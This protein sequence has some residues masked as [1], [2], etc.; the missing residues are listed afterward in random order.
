MSAPRKF[1]PLII[2]TILDM[3]GAL[4]VGHINHVATRAIRAAAAVLLSLLSAIH[5]RPSLPLPR[6]I[7]D[8]LRR[9]RTPV[10][11]IVHLLPRVR[12][13]NEN[14]ARRGV[15][16]RNS[17]QTHVQTSLVVLS[18]SSY[19]KD[20]AIP[21]TG[22]PGALFDTLVLTCIANHVINTMRSRTDWARWLRVMAG[23]L[24]I[25]VKSSNSP[26]A[27]LGASALTM[28]PLHPVLSALK[29]KLVSAV[30]DALGEA[31]YGI[32][33]SGRPYPIVLQKPHLPGVS[34]TSLLKGLT[35][36]P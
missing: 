26:F 28:S 24:E 20:Y 21:N 29:W 5:V 6:R 36:Y 2:R 32:P 4:S 16:E 34:Q 11:P 14:G 31:D 7:P 18:T 1:H 22:W 23:R 35:R 30:K 13:R 33:V 12:I 15:S 17:P 25:P 3:E 27:L 19:P 8:L 10:R 9:N